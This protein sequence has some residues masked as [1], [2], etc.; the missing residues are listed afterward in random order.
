MRAVNL[1]AATLVLAGCVSSGFAPPQEEARNLKVVRLVAMEAPPL[2][3]PARFASAWPAGAIGTFGPGAG[4]A[5][6]G[7]ILLEMPEASKRGG[8]AS[9]SSQ[10]KLAAGGSWS[11]TLV[12]AGEMK[13][14][15]TAAGISATISPTIKPMP[16]V[17]DRGYTTLMENWLAP[18]R[19]WYNSNN[20][21]SDYAGPLS[22]RR[23]WVIEVG[24]SNYEIA[25]G[26]LLLQV[27]M[28]VIDPATGKVIGRARAYDPW[29]MPPIGPFEQTFADNGKI[30]KQV[31]TAEAQKLSR[32]CLME[33]G[34]IR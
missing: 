19:A 17:V 20:A 18:I 22:G 15:L 14:Q 27:N 30:Y 9:Q 3:V 7:G 31:F 2:G 1:L 23:T 26:G 16:G 34:L 21:V 11:P 5:A 25:S 28:K 33:L 6:I 32:E 10:S 29:N 13:S 12:I 24:I 8:E 4:I